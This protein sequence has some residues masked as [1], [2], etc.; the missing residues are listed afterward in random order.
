MNFGGVGFFRALARASSRGLIA[1]LSFLSCDAS[2]IK[3]ACISASLS[4]QCCAVEITAACE[5]RTLFSVSS[6]DFSSR[7]S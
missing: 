4:L 2:R 1:S 3:F 6:W 7:L 5:A